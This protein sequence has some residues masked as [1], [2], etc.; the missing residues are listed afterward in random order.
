MIRLILTIYLFIGTAVSANEIRWIQL[1]TLPSIVRAKEATSKLSTTLNEKVSIFFLDDGWYAVSLGPYDPNEVFAVLNTNLTNKLI[2]PDSFVTDGKNYGKKVWATGS[3]AM[4]DL[5]K[6]SGNNSAEYDQNYDFD[7][8]E[9]ESE[10]LESENLLFSSIE[11][12]NPLEKAKFFDSKLSDFYKKAV[13]SALLAEGLYASK[14]D[15]QYGPGTRRA[16]TEWQINNNFEAT[17]FMTIF[18]QSELIKNYLKPL[19]ENGI[20]VEKNLLAGIKI[21]LP[22]DFK[23]PK[24]ITPPFITYEASTSSKIKVYLISQH[25]DEYDLKILFDAMQDLEIIPKDA[26]KLLLRN[27]FE[28]SGKNNEWESFFTAINSNDKIKGFGLTWPAE[29]NFIAKRLL[30]KM[31]L[32]FES[33]PGALR[34]RSIASEDQNLNEYLGFELRRPKYS[35]SGLFIDDEAR[36]ITQA[37]GLSEC[38][39]LSVNG[40][41][42]YSILNKNDYLD[43]AILAPQQI[44]KP[45]SIIKYTNAMPKI[46]DGVAL[47]S[48]PYQG[49][50]NRATLI[51][52]IL[53]EMEDLQGD[54]NKFRFSV[55]VEPGD[56]GGGIF[57]SS[58]NF[59]GL[60]LAQ[61][62]SNSN[63]D[64]QIA[65]KAREINKFLREVA[66]TELKRSY[67]TKPLDLGQIE[68]MANKVTALISCWENK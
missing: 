14:I 23:K 31:R 65:I 45:L 21:P 18:Q 64:A 61:P 59:I 24:E 27:S 6:L 40:I 42:N 8:N 44:L 60:H 39:S 63:S 12:L 30:V 56:S 38:S 48:F 2:S 35:R 4:T 15:G 19:F 68:F 13:Q 43:L 10:S 7:I 11:K 5:E 33:I 46:G 67:S 3:F 51:E 1:E 22:T 20:R 50:L 37:S 16:I 32:E 41:Y 47:A 62:F 53:R 28:L 54:K 9:K 34:E 29:E 36:I 58:G 57:D 66:S 26:K 52:G 25:G 17:G 49:K 55:P